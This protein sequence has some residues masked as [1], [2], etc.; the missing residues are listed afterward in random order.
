MFVDIVSLINEIAI[1][2]S[3]LPSFIHRNVLFVQGLSNMSHNFIVISVIT[4]TPPGSS[5]YSKILRKSPN[6]TIW[7]IFYNHCMFTD[8]CSNGV[9]KLNVPLYR[10]QLVRKSPFRIPV[11]CYFY[12]FQCLLQ[13]C[14]RIAT[15]SAL[16]V[17]FNADISHAIMQFIW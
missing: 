6:W 12:H 3:L 4:H 9:L 5:K 17:S 1:C 10:G 16:Y 2:F 7:N 11:Y 14:K 13:K 8:Y 15:E